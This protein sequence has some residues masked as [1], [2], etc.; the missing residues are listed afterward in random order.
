MDGVSPSFL[1][2]SLWDPADARA[3]ESG[4]P[5]AQVS[6]APLNF[7]FAGKLGLPFD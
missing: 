3:P 5:G 4:L 1:S 6:P 7:R 2:T